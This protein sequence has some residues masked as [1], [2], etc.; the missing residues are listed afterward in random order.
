MEDKLRQEL[1]QLSPAHLREL[2]SASGHG[3]LLRDSEEKLTAQFMDEQ[4]V[5][6]IK[7]EGNAFF[8]Q[9]RM[10]DAIS[11]YSRC[12]EMDPN[13]AVCLSNRAAAYLKLKNFDLTVEDCTKAIAVAPTIKPFMRRAT[14]YIA[15]HSY[16][17]AVADLAAALEFEP[18][19]NEC[20]AMLQAVVDTATDE[21][22]E[23]VTAELHRAGVRAA[24]IHSAREGWEKSVVRGNPGPAAVNGHTLFKGDKGRIYLLGGRAVREQKLDVFVLNESDGSWDT[25]STQGTTSP[26]SRAWHSTSAIGS[27]ERGFYC[28]Y[29]G[30]SSRGEDPNVHLLIPTSPRGFQWL[31]PLSHQDVKDIPVSRSG[32]AAVSV[33]DNDNRAVFIFG[34]R[35]KRGVSDQL[36]ILRCLPARTDINLEDTVISWEEITPQ[37]TGSE[38][39]PNWPSARDGH[40]MCLLPAGKQAPRLIVFGGN[41][42]LNDERMNDVWV[43][44]MEIH[45]WTL[46]QCYG[47][48]PPPRS[49]HTAHTVGEFLFVV[50]GRTA[51]SEDG[52]VYMLNVQTAEWFKVPVPDDHALTPRA[53]HSSVLTEAGQIFVLGGGTY[54]GPLKEAAT[55]DLSYFQSK[56]SSL[57]QIP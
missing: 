31:Q 35:T 16:E 17:K 12:I 18:K 55:L 21:R 39:H 49:Y 1:Q 11:A 23:N 10:N 48:I 26:S 7:D 53:W 44:D 29:G 6:K 36:L 54:H 20:R 45:R 4:L 47:D 15:L 41:G 46:L 43:F 50:G 3:Q 13:N 30:V 38:A 33:E 5:A 40:S 28:V 51:E 14:A 56:A 19:N 8:R 57:S 34:G 2:L 52:S 9:G 32:H 42:Q 37:D 25:I 24:V 22:E 27:Y